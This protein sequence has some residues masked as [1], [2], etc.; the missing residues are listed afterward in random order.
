MLGG[1]VG[2]NRKAQGS[3]RKIWQSR[4]ALSEATFSAEWVSWD[5]RQYED[6]SV[7]QQRECVNKYQYQPARD[8]KTISGT[9][10]LICIGS[11]M[12]SLGNR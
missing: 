3:A 12:S 2:P 7:L 6:M 5:A 9:V 4:S 8:S 10:K 11:E 1:D